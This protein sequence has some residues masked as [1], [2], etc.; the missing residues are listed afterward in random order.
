MARIDAGEV[1]LR[2]ERLS[3]LTLVEDVLSLYREQLHGRTVAIS[4]DAAHLEVYGDRKILS[5]ALEQF[6]DNASKYSAPGS[7]ISVTAEE[8]LGEIVIGVHNE[9]RSGT[10]LREILPG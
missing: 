9:G 4:E 3:V 7:P 6:V 5:A 10:D 2:R 1:R 8:S